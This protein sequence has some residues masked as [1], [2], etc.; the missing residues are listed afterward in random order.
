[1]SKL[2]KVNKFLDVS[3]YGRPVARGI[4]HTLKNTSFNAV[5]VTLLFVV[6]GLASIYCMLYGYYY[7]AAFFLILK[8]ILDAADGELARLKEEPSY[9]GRFLDSVSDIVLNLLFLLTIRYITDG[10]WLWMTVAFFGIQLQGTLYNYYYVILRNQ[11]NGD[12]TSRIFESDVP[13]ALPGEKQKN[14]TILFYMYKTLYV[15][16][17]KTIYQLDPK[18][19]TSG[20]FPNWFMTAVSTLALGFQLLIM[21]V[22]FVVNKP[23]LII[24]VFCFL[25]LGILVLITIRRGIGFN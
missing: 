13:K 6:S 5:H 12:K 16:F 23:N 22:L 14:V 9:V 24:P 15:I 3:D 18:A 10:S 11:Y 21:A 25:T 17:D 7:L 8:S 4:A 2:P 20:S 1:M 19:S